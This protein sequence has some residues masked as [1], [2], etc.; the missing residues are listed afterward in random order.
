MA[1]RGKNIVFREDNFR[2]SQTLTYLFADTSINLSII[3]RKT[4]ANE[5]FLEDWSSVRFLPRGSEAMWNDRILIACSN[6][7]SHKSANLDSSI[8]YWKNKF[9]PY[10]FRA[11]NLVFKYNFLALT[12]N[13]FL[14]SNAS[15]HQCRTSEFDTSGSL[16]APLKS[17][18]FLN[19]NKWWL[20]KTGHDY[21][22]IQ[23]RIISINFQLTVPRLLKFSTIFQEHL[24]PN[25]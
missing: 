14:S 21:S 17:I 1:N 23:C 2:G 11:W 24:S 13:S 22:V 9:T 5:F 3:T 18:F 7:Q 6:L 15:P 19:N 4:C 25:N 10:N 20:S 16:H 12:V 8:A